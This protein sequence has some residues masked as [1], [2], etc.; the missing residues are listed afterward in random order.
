VTPGPE[1]IQPTGQGAA[2]RAVAVG[3]T[4]GLGAG[5]TTALFMF[6]EL[7]AVTLSADAIV[8][9]LYLA[10]EIRAAMVERFGRAILDDNGEIDRGRLR[11]A[12][13]G[14]RA[15]LQW[16][17][18]LTHPRVGA[19]IERAIREAPPGA[20]VVCE[21][22]LLFEAGLR[23]RFRLVLT[24]EASPGVRLARSAD[25]FDKQGFSE[26]DSFQAGT[27]RRVQG[28]DMVFYN[29]GALENMRAFV[30]EAYARALAL[31]G[32]GG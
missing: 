16:L 19:A 25:R 11:E 20:V 15:A 18:R 31:S 5:K 23:D 7:G 32:A 2:N 8:H 21:V 3:L 30:R 6:R 10:P 4:G 1:K 24:V 9:S 28:S 14:D 29:D 17:E 13:R 26:F 12:V 22:P 27:E